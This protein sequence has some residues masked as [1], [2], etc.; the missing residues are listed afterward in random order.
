MYTTQVAPEPSGS[1]SDTAHQA[2]LTAWVAWLQRT[3]LKNLLSGPTL[4]HS[5][6]M[7]GSKTL[8]SGDSMFTQLR[9]SED[10][11]NW[12][13][14]VFSQAAERKWH[15]YQD[16][17]ATGIHIYTYMPCVCFL[18]E[19]QEWEWEG[20]CWP[21]LLL[22]LVEDRALVVEGLLTTVLQ[23]QAL[24]KSKGQRSENDFLNSYPSIVTSNS[25][26]H[27]PYEVSTLSCSYPVGGCWR[28]RQDVDFGGN[29]LSVSEKN[30]SNTAHYVGLL[31]AS[32]ESCL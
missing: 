16:V 23:S 31:Q 5:C 9:T 30:T 28:L 10:T 4:P 14:E 18:W 1:K 29:T 24:D 25:S 11:T 13:P 6:D 22:F 8:Q 21:V 15:C 7:H 12:L 3:R 17:W 32:V 2:V 26:L 19:N 20:S 27:S